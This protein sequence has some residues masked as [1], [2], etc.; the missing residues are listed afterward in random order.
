MAVRPR[1]L[2]RRIAARLAAPSAPPAP[3]A[4]T[5]AL[6]A[7]V[8]RDYLQALR[9]G[10]RG[11]V[12]DLRQA[13]ALYDRVLAAAPDHAP[14]LIERL[15]ADAGLRSLTGVADEPEHERA[16]QHTA[17]RLLELDPLNARARLVLAEIAISSRDWRRAIELVDEALALT[18]DDARLLRYQALVLARTGYLARAR[19]AAERAAMADPMSANS[20]RGLANIDILL[21]DNQRMLESVQLAE[22][23][24]LRST[25]VYRAFAALRRGEHAQAEAE[26]RATL[27]AFGARD[28]WVGPVLAAAADASR[29]DAALRALDAEPE[30][31]RKV[32][33]RFVV[34][35]AV[36][37]APE[38]SLQALPT[39][40]QGR[41]SDWTQHVWAPEMSV[42]RQHEG[43]TR[44]I[45]AMGFTALWAARGAPDRCWRERATYRCG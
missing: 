17:Q 23:L 15:F 1:A 40:A 5:A 22:D 32:Q 30:A 11:N 19:A 7:A 24:G 41:A 6:P 20:F 2:P 21:G 36:A 29:R 3:A 34:F 35:Y 13:L 25:H 44:Y 14:A 45:E 39:L 4:P 31:A 33:D 26:F 10:R 16:R 12:D 18:P 28:E 9:L 38:R 37:G 42:V 43:F 8:Y 27:K